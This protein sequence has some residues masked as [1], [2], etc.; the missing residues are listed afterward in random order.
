MLIN[1]EINLVDPHKA[2]IIACQ[3]S[4][5]SES[6]L[7][8]KSS[9]YTI[10]GW[11]VPAMAC[12]ACANGYHFSRRTANYEQF[13]WPL[14]CRMTTRWILSPFPDQASDYAWCCVLPPVETRHVWSLQANMCLAIRH[15]KVVFAYIYGHILWARWQ[16]GDCQCP[17]TFKD[18]WQQYFS[19]HR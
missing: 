13:F 17:I 1:H 15:P 5:H 2:F 18:W 8:D 7:A 12:H 3:M 11:W 19:I 10:H 9:H 14:S 6:W 16:Q 4:Q